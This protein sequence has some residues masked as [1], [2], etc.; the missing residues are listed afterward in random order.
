MMTKGDFVFLATVIGKAR[1]CPK[2]QL[3]H[4][5]AELVVALSKQYGNF[6]ADKFYDFL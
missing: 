2:C 6:D 5:I 4:F 1:E 3:S